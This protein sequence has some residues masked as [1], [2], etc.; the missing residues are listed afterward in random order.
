MK[1]SNVLFVGDDDLL[2]GTVK[3]MLAKKK[4][5]VFFVDSYEDALELLDREMVDVFVVDIDMKKNNAMQLL[6]AIKERYPNIIRLVFGTYT[7]PEQLLSCINQVEIFR[8]IKK[9][10]IYENLW[11]FI[12]ESFKRSAHQQNQRYMIASLEERNAKLAKT[13]CEK[14]AVEKH[15]ETLSVTDDLTGIYNRRQFIACLDHEFQQ[16]LR[17]GTDFSLMMLD[18]DNFKMVNDTFGHSFGDFVLKTF[19]VRVGEAIRETDTLFRYGGEEFMVLLT[20]TALPAA[21]LLGRRILSENRHTPYVIEQNFHTC[22]VSIGIVSYAS[23]LPKTPGNLIEE[24]DRA[25]YRAKQNGR[26]QLVA[27]ESTATWASAIS[28]Y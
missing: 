19:A 10:I 6:I 21:R 4:C 18:L 2:L 7:Y 22:T 13:L 3:R 9:P 17:Y 25:L 11:E 26:D 27:H 15:F 5:G 8:F 14:N 12:S 16:S 20:N 1:S 28:R 24:V 23:T